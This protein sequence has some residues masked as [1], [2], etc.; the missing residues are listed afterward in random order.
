M[1]TYSFKSVIYLSINLKKNSSKVITET[2]INEHFGLYTKAIKA[3]L[4]RWYKICMA[5]K[6]LLTQP[7]K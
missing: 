5:V 3:I 4:Y 2:N 6:I 7:N 1:I